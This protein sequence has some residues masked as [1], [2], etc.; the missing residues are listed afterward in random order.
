MVH[1]L[2]DPGGGAGFCFGSEDGRL[3]LT[4]ENGLVLGDPVQAVTSREAVN[5]VVRH[6]DYLAVSTR[7]DITF[8]TA[9][10]DESLRRSLLSIGAHGL[11]VTRTG[12][13]VASAGRPGWVFAEP[14]R[15]GRAEPVATQIDWP[16]TY[17]YRTVVL[18]DGRGNDVLAC[19]MRKAG[20]GAARF[21][22]AKGGLS[23]GQLTY[24]SFVAA[25]LC[26]I[27]G[28]ADPLAVAAAGLDGTLVFYRDVLTDRDPQA[29]RMTTIEG[30]V[31]RIMA[32][33]GHLAVLTSRAL[34]LL[35]D[36][37]TE[38][39]SAVG[40]PLPARGFVIPVKAVDAN[41]VADRYILVVK[42]DNI[43][44][45]VDV[46]AVAEAVAR[47]IPSSSVAGLGS[48]IVSL[49][50]VE[51]LRESAARAMAAV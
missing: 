22:G 35:P 27:G 11:A 23:L 29:W 3:L 51:Y 31:Y 42:D 46:R 16:D 40:R 30:E 34:Y 4:D 20:V 2:P 25:D 39:L 41:A 5:D 49:R 44:L 47:N 43:V 48:Q 28:P 7:A 14:P 32:C 8:M 1:A 37:V 13:F 10:T 50:G 36:V 24:P 45:R 21:N 9:S 15:G 38:F 18:D 33:H 26:G 6:G 12:V 19:A 17:M